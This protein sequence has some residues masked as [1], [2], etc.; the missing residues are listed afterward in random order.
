[1]RIKTTSLLSVQ[2]L[3]IFTRNPFECFKFRAFPTWRT[4]RSGYR[5]EGG[6]TRYSGFSVCTSFGTKSPSFRTSF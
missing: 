6:P 4:G 5:C 3:N 1:M 2:Y